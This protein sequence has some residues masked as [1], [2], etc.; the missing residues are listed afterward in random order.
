MIGIDFFQLVPCP[1]S[2]CHSNMFARKP[3]S[4]S[5]SFTKHRPGK[6]IAKQKRSFRDNVAASK[7][8]ER[9]KRPENS[10]LGRYDA[11]LSVKIEDRI[12]T[13]TAVR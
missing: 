11:F 10:P 2:R 1:V 5:D 9:I 6:T 4:T 7:R 13:L 8:T 3:N 12:L